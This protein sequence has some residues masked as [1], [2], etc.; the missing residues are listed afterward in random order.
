MKEQ[1]AIQFV[2]RAAGY[3]YEYFGEETSFKGTVGHFELLEDMNCCAPTNT[4]LFAF[5][6]ANRRK[7]MG[8]EELLDFLKQCRKVD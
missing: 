2:E 3:Q 5:Y 8:A 1:Q 4:V 7:V 6:T